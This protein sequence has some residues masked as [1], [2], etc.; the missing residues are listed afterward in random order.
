MCSNFF[1][2][3]VEKKNDIFIK[4]LRSDMGKEL[5]NSKCFVKITE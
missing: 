2:A 3:L 1:K 5:M 4:L